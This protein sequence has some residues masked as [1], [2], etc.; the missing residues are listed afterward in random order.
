M[1]C[2]A[3]ASGVSSAY[4][5]CPH[6][7]CL[8]SGAHN[9]TAAGNITPAIAAPC[10]PTGRR[11]RRCAAAWCARAPP[12]RRCW[13]TWAAQPLRQRSAAHLTG[14]QAARQLRRLLLCTPMSRQRQ[15]HACPT[16]MPP[17][18]QPLIP[19]I[20]GQQPLHLP[21]GPAPPGAALHPEPAADI[22]RSH[23]ACRL[24]HAALA[25][26]GP[27]ACAGAAAAAAVAA[28]ARLLLL[29][30]AANLPRC[31]DHGAACS[32]CSEACRRGWCHGQCFQQC[33]ANC[34]CSQRPTVQRVRAHILTG[35]TRLA[36]VCRVL[37]TLQCM[38]GPRAHRHS[39]SSG[40]LW[41]LAVFCG[42][43]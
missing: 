25:A 24:W 2:S 22:A 27:A 8:C 14:H 5:C 33:C 34:S 17:R 43:D 28:A 39:G 23:A 9:L 7:E 35:S 12:C 4:K 37:P 10:G 42:G 20:L 29:L 40:A 30:A 32:G 1:W 21:D 36:D 26:A 41:L 6:M 15:Q 18:S 3:A 11:C 13:A 19:P 16:C 38:P 31:N